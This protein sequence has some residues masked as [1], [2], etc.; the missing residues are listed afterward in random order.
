MPLVAALGMG[1]WGGSGVGVAP[2]PNFQECDL[3]VEHFRKAIFPAN[4]CY[5]IESGA[6]L[7]TWGRGFFRTWLVLSAIWIG[8]WVYFAGP[9]TY[10]RLWHAPKYDIE[11]T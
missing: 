5:A 7:M 9:K 8:L 6:R 2:R 11:F 1:F 3:R 4:R 10:S